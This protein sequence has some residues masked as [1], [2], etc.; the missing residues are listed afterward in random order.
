MVRGMAPW[1]LHAV[2]LAAPEI[3]D[4]LDNDGD[5]D[6]DDPPLWVGADGDGD[7][8]GSPSGATLVSSCS[9][10]DE[11]ASIDDCDD[12][13]TSVHPGAV[14]DCNGIDDDCD[15]EVD[16]A[17]CAC[18]VAIDAG[19]VLQLCD[20]TWLGWHDARDACE[21]DGF[22]L[23][24][25]R[26]EV[27][28]DELWAALGPL[29]NLTANPRFGTWLG[30][31]DEA[32]EGVWVWV[33]GEVAP[34]TNWRAGEPNNGFYMDVQNTLEHCAEIEAEGT[35]DDQS[36]AVIH[37]YA[38]ERPCE[39]RTFWADADGDGLG[40]PNTERQTCSPLSSEVS[41]GLD[42]DDIDASQPTVRYI[43]IDGDGV[44]SEPNVGCSPEGEILAGDCDDNNELVNPSASETCNGIDDDCIGGIDD[45]DG[46]PWWPDG[47]GDGWGSDDVEPLSTLCA[48]DGWVSVT[49]DCDDGVE[50][51]APGLSDAPG[52]GIDSDC[53]GSDAPAPDTDGDGLTDPV[54]EIYHTDPLDPDTDEDALS[55]GE[56]ITLGTDPLLPDSDADGL[57]DGEEP[58]VDTDGDGLID[59]LDD[60]DDGDGLP[61]LLDT[62]GDIDEDGLLGRLDPDS[63]GDGVMDGIDPDPFDAG[64]MMQ[65]EK[66]GQPDAGCSCAQPGA[67]SGAVVSWLGLLAALGARRTRAGLR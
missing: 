50:S 3:C 53:D 15:G 48:P 46:G 51:I 18:T 60:D 40:D 61:T 5:G 44:G 22:T 45:G 49:G 41:N 9:A 19:R 56:E 36:C 21:A 13:D 38:C 67:P 34:Y 39:E 42:C 14:E 17:A 55:D 20:V 52:D 32:E 54:E 64:G 2:A 30:A 59:P 28:Q 66:P 8:Y 27:E 12:G 1:L 65:P 33:D 16:E 62:A 4:G 63:D 11:A 35:W 57:S 58:A 29:F 10:D 47:D 26:S 7:G 6:I 37:P 24:L 31:T 43:D 25:V 23:P